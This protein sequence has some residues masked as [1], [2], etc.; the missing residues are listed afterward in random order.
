MLGNY[1][2]KHRLALLTYL[3]LGLTLIPSAAHANADVAFTWDAGVHLLI[4]TLLAGMIAAWAIGKIFR[5]GVGAAMGTTILAN[6]ASVLINLVMTPIFLDAV[7]PLGR[8]ASMPLYNS[9]KAL[10]ALALELFFISILLQLPFFLWLF[11]HQYQG[12]ERLR[13]SFKASFVGQIACY[14][15]FLPWIAM[16]GCGNTYDNFAIDRNLSFARSSTARVYYISPDDGDV[17]IVR[18]DGAQRCKAFDTN[19]ARGDGRLF[20]RPSADRK[21]WDLWVKQYRGRQYQR[22]LTSGLIEPSDLPIKAAL[23]R[24]C[25]Y[26]VELRPEGQRNWELIYKKLGGVTA[27][28]SK[29]TI[30]F[31]VSLENVVLQW[32]ARYATILPGDQVVYQLG[33]Q[34]II[35]DLN[36]RKIGL[37]AVGRSPVVTLGGKE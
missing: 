14:A 4:G 24:Y 30:R 15:F 9:N 3:I 29:L 20:I 26:A 1:S 11:R 17:Y 37:L 5:V 7:P 33:D 31:K 8:L 10:W 21:S 23:P 6:Y 36:K 2:K 27:V 13:Y 28:N 32:E 25:Y 18:A 16:L 12:L 19:I 35:L 22:I 34:I